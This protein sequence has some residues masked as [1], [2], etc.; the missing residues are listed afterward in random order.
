MLQHW[1]WLT[2]RHGLGAAGIARLL[3]EFG[4]AEAV[5]EA[6]PAQWKRAHLNE[7]ECRA[8]E[9]RDLTEAEALL[10]TCYEQNIHILTAADPHY[11]ERLRNIDAPPALLYYKGTFPAFD[12]QIA[13][14]VVGTRKATPYGM[15]KAKQISREISLKGG[16]IV[17]G[18]AQGID[19]MAVIGG[20]ETDRPVA[21]VLGCGVDVV[22]PRSNRSLYD[23][24]IRR[25]CLISQ[26]PPGTPPLARNFPIRNRIMSSLCLG[27]L[28]VEAPE[29]SG[30]LITARQALEQGRDVFAVPGSA[31]AAT[32]AGSNALIQQGAMLVTQ[33]ADVIGEYAARFP[34]K[35]VPGGLYFDPARLEQ[36][37]SAINVELDK[38]AGTVASPVAPIAKPQK[39]SIDNPKPRDYIDVH[40]VKALLSAEEGQVLEAVTPEPIAVDDVIERC[41]L[42]ASRVLA[43]ITML[44]I[45]KYITR[46][47]GKRIQLARK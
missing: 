14:A 30:A 8:L 13:I 33:G 12:D 4:T 19:T 21:A 6:E 32:C 36:R 42:P 35:L 24:L 31:G 47:P 28:V 18:L 38:P 26:F 22:Y 10:A 23:E 1:I 25:G 40:E 29:K 45:R 16:L 41:A 44:E 7:R 37:I 20:L 11:P 34:E 3:E 43:A 15:M 5:F 39:K 27:V 9:E 2:T 46:L 17:S